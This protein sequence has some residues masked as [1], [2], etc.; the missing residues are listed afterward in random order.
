MID[1]LSKRKHIVLLF[2]ICVFL[3]RPGSQLGPAQAQHCLYDHCL[4]VLSMEA[5]VSSY[6]SETTIRRSI[7]GVLSNGLSNTPRNFLAFLCAT[8]A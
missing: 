6:G 4:Y 8:Y 7:E 1:R 5:D 2:F 3:A